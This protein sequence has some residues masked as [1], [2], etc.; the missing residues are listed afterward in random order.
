MP[1]VKNKNEGSTGAIPTTGLR[2]ARAVAADRGI[3]LITIWRWSKRKWILTVNISGKVYVDMA[4]LAEFDRKAAAGE[5]ADHRQARRRPVTKPAYYPRKT[6]QSALWRFRTD[7]S[8]MD[9][10][11]QKTEIATLRKVRLWT[12]GFRSERLSRVSSCRFSSE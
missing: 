2:A 8:P 7:K 12:R 6:C 9:A 5:F 11:H 10:K 3:S 1:I 4:S